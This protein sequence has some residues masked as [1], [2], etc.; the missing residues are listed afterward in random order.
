MSGQWTIQERGSDPRWT[1]DD[2]FVADERSNGYPPD[3]LVTLRFLRNA[4]R[5]HLLLWVVVALA[6]LSA[7]VATPFVLPP[8]SE[9]SAKLLLTYS[10]T[11]DRAWEM[12]TDVSLVGTQ[13]VA[14]LAI[15]KLGLDVAPDELL[16]QYAA[17][18][19]TDRVLKITAKAGTS[20]EATRLVGALAQVYL[21]FRME[22]IA[23]QE[24]PL[25]KDLEAAKAAVAKAETD[26]RKTGGDPNDPAPAPSP[27]V[28]RLSQAREKQEYIEE[29]IINQQISASRMS[30]SRIL[31]PATPV[32]ASARRAIVFSAG[33][34]LVA[35]L[36]LGLGFVIV[37]ALISDRLWRRQDISLALGARIQ[38]SIGRPPWRIGWFVRR[39]QLR[40]PEIQRAVRHLADTIRWDDTP[41]PALAIVSVDDAD[42]GAL[43]TASLALRIAEEGKQVLVADLTGGSVGATL[44]AD[45]PGTHPS[46]LNG[47]QVRIAVHL[48]DPKDG[49]VEGL[50]A[51]PREASVPRDE[52][53]TAT[54]ASADLIL[55][56]ATLNPAIGAEYLRTWSPRAVALVTA[57]R[58]T[59]TG[60]RSVGE[61]LRLAGV[62]LEPSI[63]LRGDRTDDSV[64][65]GDDELVAP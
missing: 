24:V 42:A 13:S 35:G 54:W 63:V 61:M 36:F 55:V 53:L 38:L 27:E 14:Q 7:G 56:L 6:G 45:A 59:A 8:A 58:C 39:A 22:Q 16:Q 64:G 4:V 17:I 43:V 41:K 9:S 50:L 26:V 30:S 65:T 5:R 34:G 1:E 23:Q 11:D 52:T 15:D 47:D 3:G 48:P 40:K 25:R 51:P 18:P 44:G 10:T 12:S 49:P 31:D 19:M 37:R 20:E 57:G 28:T 33:S 32:P 21:T 62:G 60:L 2:L 29:Q 46:R